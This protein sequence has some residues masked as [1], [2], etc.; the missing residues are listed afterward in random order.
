[1]FEHDRYEQLCA[2]AAVGQ[3]SQEDL[4]E[5]Q[6]H[7]SA[8]T[9]CEKLQS[10]L[11]E[12]NSICLTPAEESKQEVKDRQAVLRLKILRGLA[13]AGA[14]FSAPVQRELFEVHIWRPSWKDFLQ[15]FNLPR[16]IAATLLICALAG[17]VSLSIW[18]EH[19]RAVQ[20]AANVELEKKPSAV[21][22]PPSSR[23]VE[24]AAPRE[25]DAQ[26]VQRLDKSARRIASFDR[27][28]RISAMR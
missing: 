17:A 12:V 15:S 14:T 7:L 4:A 11:I 2:E 21:T 20:N 19:R 18:H 1:M 24:L 26:L 6:R 22:L 8:C 9:I 27:S 23:G 28:L 25:P 3:I 16:A 10:D 13:D 5:L